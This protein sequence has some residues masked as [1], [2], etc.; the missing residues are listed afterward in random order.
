MIW[1]RLCSDPQKKHQ[2]RLCKI[3]Q[4]ILNGSEKVDVICQNRPKNTPKCPPEELDMMS[5]TN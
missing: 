4:N 5:K 2:E 1:K 3:S